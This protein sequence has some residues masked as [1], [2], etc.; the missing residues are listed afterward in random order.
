MKN[1]V[2]IFEKSS[3]GQLLNQDLFLY[4]FFIINALLI[5]AI[6]YLATI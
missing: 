2:A 6:N 4:F 1:T 3:T 5:S